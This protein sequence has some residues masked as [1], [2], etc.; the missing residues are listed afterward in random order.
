LPDGDAR[1]LS[2]EIFPGEPNQYSGLK[3]NQA[4]HRSKVHDV[5]A[6]H[7]H[8]E[9]VA[10]DAVKWAHAELVKVYASR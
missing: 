9:R 7:A 8:T 6:P 2:S 3:A 1:A 5:R 10:E 4:E